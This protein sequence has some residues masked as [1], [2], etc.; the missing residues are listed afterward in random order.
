MWHGDRRSIDARNK[1]SSPTKGVLIFKS[2]LV[3]KG[4]VEGGCDI[5]RPSRNKMSALCIL[6]TLCIYSAI[7]G[8]D[9]IYTGSTR[10]I[11]FVVQFSVPFT[12]SCNAALSK[13]GNSFSRLSARRI[14][15]RHAFALKKNRCGTA[16]VSKVSDNEHTAASLGH[17]EVLSVQHPVGPPIPE[18]AQRPEEGTKI[19]SL[20]AGQDAG[21]VFP[22]NPSRP[23]T[24]SDCKKC[25]HEVPSRVF[26]S[27]PQTG[28]AERLTGGSSDK[29]VNC[30]IGPLSELSHVPAIRDVR[31]MVRENGTWELLNLRKPCGRPTHVMPRYGSCFNA[32]ADRDV[33]HRLP[34]CRRASLRRSCLFLSCLT[35]QSLHAAL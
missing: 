4:S 14:I 10:T 16:P 3:R 23:V 30:F 31:V 26:E 19:P 24:P 20:S 15:P 9:N 8:S 22:D 28:D 6:G 1:A 5:D 35:M 25:K 18:L 34:L 11:A 27:S 12:T 7:N 29:K 33:L 13:A 21:D 32:G 17:S 2:L